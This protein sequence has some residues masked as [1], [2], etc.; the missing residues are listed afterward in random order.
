MTSEERHIQLTGVLPYYFFVQFELKKI[1][2][3]NSILPKTEKSWFN[4]L[5]SSK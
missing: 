1:I 5:F 2:T 4:K 3:F